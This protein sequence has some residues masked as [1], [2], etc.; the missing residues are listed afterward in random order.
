MREKLATETE[1]ARENKRMYSEKVQQLTED[2]ED[3]DAKIE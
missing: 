1:K 2:V 3:K